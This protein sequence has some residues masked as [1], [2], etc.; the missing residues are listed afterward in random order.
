MDFTSRWRV[1]KRMQHFIPD[2]S[3]IY[4]TDEHCCH[5]SAPS[6]FAGTKKEE[7]GGESNKHFLPRN[8]R[9]HHHRLSAPPNAVHR[10]TNERAPRAPLPGI[11]HAH[12]TTTPGMSVHTYACTAVCVEAP[13]NKATVVAT[14]T[15]RRAAVE[16][17]ARP[18]PW[19]RTTLPPVVVVYIE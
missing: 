8:W 3:L 4:S 15:D 13:G 16:G 6:T 7:E 9:I 17:R 2:F 5:S 18:Q 14:A 12:C 1:A 11:T 19:P 10:G